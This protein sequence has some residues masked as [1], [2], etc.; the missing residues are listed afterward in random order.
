VRSRHRRVPRLVRDG[1][2][3]SGEHLRRHRPLSH[4]LWPAVHDGRSMCVRLLLE[5]RVLQRRLHR[6]G[7]VLQPTRP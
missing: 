7:D 2:R 5:R 6:S 3:L 4:Q 1:R